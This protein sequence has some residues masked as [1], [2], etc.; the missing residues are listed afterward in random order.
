VSDADPAELAEVAEALGE[1]RTHLGQFEQAEAAFRLAGRWAGSDLDRARLGYAV[2]LAAERRGDYRRCLQRLS[3]AERLLRDAPG[4]DA[5]RLQAQVRAQYGLVRHRQGRGTD[6]VRLL[7]EAVALAERT[8]TAP[9]LA[10]A[11][12]HL[13]VAEL[14]VGLPG[15]GEHAERALTILREAGG[16]PWLEARALNQLGIRSYYAGRWDEAVQRYAASRAA[17]ERAGDAWTAAIASGNIAEVLSDQGHLAEA[18][19]ALERAMHTYRAAGTPAFVADGTRLLGRLAAR[20]GEHE[21]AEQLLTSA[22]MQFADD[23][24]DLQVGLTDAY[25]AEAALLAGEPGTALERAGAAMAEVAGLPA[26]G[27]VTPL[28]HRVLGLAWATLGDRHSA[29]DDLQA[30]IREARGRRSTYDLAL[31]LRALADLEGEA[32]PEAEAEAADLERRLGLV[33]AAAASRAA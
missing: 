8:G 32:V 27:L 21:R 12:L 31:S 28:L 3:A 2:A 4:A 16:Q 25:L 17:C 20:Q 13:D 14:T 5:A 10:T 23:G 29:V 19:T 7:R 24:E 30:S 33:R 15:E 18:R 1:A 11:L 6:A 9:I 26:R 22:R